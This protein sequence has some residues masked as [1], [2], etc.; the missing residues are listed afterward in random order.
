MILPTTDYTPLRQAKSQL[1]Q[2][3]RSQFIAPQLEYQTKGLQLQEKGL[4][5]TISHITEQQNINTLHFM[6]ETGKTMVEAAFA[7]GKGAQMAKAQS[8]GNGMANA[9]QTKVN[10]MVSSGE[11]YVS[12]YTDQDPTDAEGG[13]TT[14]YIVGMDKLQAFQEGQLQQIESQNWFPSVKKQTISAMQNIYSNGQARMLQDYYANETK[15][16]FQLEQ[17]NLADAIDMDIASST[18]SSPSYTNTMATIANMNRGP[19]ASS[20]LARS[21]VQDIDL[22][23]AANAVR[24]RAVSGGSLAGVELAN[25]I[26]DNRGYN[27]DTRR[28]LETYANGAAHQAKINAQNAGTQFMQDFISSGNPDFSS[29]YSQADETLKGKPSE[30]AD[31][32]REGM[33][34]AHLAHLTP[35]FA[36]ASKDNPKY[37]TDTELQERVEQIDSM[38]AMFRGSDAT[39]ELFD[40][41]RGKYA[42]PLSAK[43]K[44]EEHEQVLLEWDEKLSDPQNVTEDDIRNDDRLSRTEKRM[45][46]NALRSAKRSGGN[47]A[48]K[49]YLAQQNALLDYLSPAVTGGQMT[50][51][52]AMTLIGDVMGDA[53]DKTETGEI[54]AQTKLK[55]NTTG[56]KLMDRIKVDLKAKHKASFDRI[57]KIIAKDV[58]AWSKADKKLVGDVAQTQLDLQRWAEGELMS[59]LCEHP[60]MTDKQVDEAINRITNAYIGETFNMLNKPVVIDTKTTEAQAAMEYTQRFQEQQEGLVYNDKSSKSLEYSPVF[61][62]K[63]DGAM[64]VERDMLKEN[65]GIDVKDKYTVIN[66]N[67]NGT[68]KTVPMF[69]DKNDKKYIVM[70]QTVYSIAENDGGADRN[71]REKYKLVPVP[72]KKNLTHKGYDDIKGIYRNV[73]GDYNAGY[74]VGSQANQDMYSMFR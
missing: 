48:E 12:T 23:V 55:I 45:F 26:S 54:S 69:E 37:M 33:Q 19:N 20:V 7:A 40:K 41:L 73:P 8:M 66:Y 72:I 53:Y 4:D 17:Q 44:Q 24:E 51:D 21:S 52:D 3:K 28:K 6:Y 36:K 34:K 2:A 58:D 14:A 65:Y 39:E 15:A 68:R 22:G 47:Q 43:E 49:D 71:A 64:R 10:E 56:L 50:V 46:I 29:A 60:D 70:D 62:E 74:S 59:I 61:G 1:A 13:K 30:Q 25:Q 5:K 16:R 35:I 11:M 67:D 57:Q 27:A 32:Y 38:E 31:A 18:L 63:Y 9:W 42:D